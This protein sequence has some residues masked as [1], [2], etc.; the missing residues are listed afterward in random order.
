VEASELFW[1]RKASPVG[2]M[3]LLDGHHGPT[4]DAMMSHSTLAGLLLATPFAHDLLPLSAQLLPWLQRLGQLLQAFRAQP[5]TPLTTAAF[6]NDLQQHVLSLG[7]TTLE[8]AFNHIE[9]AEAAQSPD[10]L[11]FDGG[12]YRRRGKS[13]NTLATLFGPVTLRRLLYE[14][15]YPGWR[16]VF[17]LQRQLGIVAGAAT[18]A[19]AQ[20]VGQLAVQGPQRA[21]L[22][23]L[24]QDHDIR[25][26]CKTLRLV[27]HALALGMSEQRQAVQTRR[28]LEWLAVAQKSR[29]RHRPVL[30]AG[31]DGIHLPMR[32]GCYSEGATGTLTVFDRRG[33]RL[34]TVYLGRMPEE[35]QVTLSKQLTGL[36]QDVLQQ[37]QGSPPRLAYVTDGGWHPTDYFF[38]VLRKMADPRRPGQRLTW[39]RVIDFYHAA[40]YI[41]KLAEALFEQPWMARHCA[42]RMRHRLKHEEHG[43]TR[44]LQSAS[45]HCNEQK[46]TGARAEAFRQAYNY[47]AKRGKQMAYARYRRLGVPLGSGITEASCKTVFTQRLKQ[48]GMRWEREGGQAIVDLRV[49]WLSGVW[50][51]VH[52][53]FLQAQTD[54]LGD[55]TFW[56]S[57]NSKRRA[58]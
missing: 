45:Y 23:A 1:L 36:I 22:K 49:L 14:P 46:L 3:V 21:V 27:T 50:D 15:C 13:P 48:S 5:V 53:A 29:G 35:K 12:T 24:R 32:K 17:P 8:W 11:D 54:Q 43:L 55:T 6:E 38:A 39:E 41:T 4:E 58:G 16:C 40:S 26:S 56:F 47:L 28:V 20:R 2:T 19:L 31:R 42:K 10:R 37:W 7:R 52:R 18:P 51:E 9:P 25:W 30:A 57:A 34:G 33:K 44:V